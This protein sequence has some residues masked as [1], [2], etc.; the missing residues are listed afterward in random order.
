MQGLQMNLKT[1]KKKIKY[2]FDDES[3]PVWC[4]GG[5]IAF[6]GLKSGQKQGGRCLRA[7]TA[8]TIPTTTQTLKHMLNFHRFWI[9]WYQESIQKLAQ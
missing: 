4:E 7:R 3:S 2:R 1:Q 6:W 8:K 9:D 5:G